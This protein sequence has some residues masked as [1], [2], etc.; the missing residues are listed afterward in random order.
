MLNCIIVDDEEGARLILE[1][2]ISKL[3]YLHLSGKFANALD[4]FH[5]LKTNNVDVILLDVNMPEVSGFGLLNM[6]S[7]RPMV[8]FTTAY[9]DYALKGF[10][11]NAIDYLHKPI[12]FER[13]VTAIEKALKWSQVTEERFDVSNITLKSDGVALQVNV[14]GILYIESL[15]NYI[16][17]HTTGKNHIVHL[18]MNEI[19]RMLPVKQFVRV[20]KSYIINAD[21]AEESNEQLIINNTA[22]PVGKTYKKYFTEYMRTRAG[23]GV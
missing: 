17:V 14:S 10:D 2:Y 6:L 21:M 16:K 5:F 1:D 19:E 22:I 18:T 7:H 20:H 8:I 9:S 3:N 13:F 4:A 23:K 15:G 11:Y 12:R